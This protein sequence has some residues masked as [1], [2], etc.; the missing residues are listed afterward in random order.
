MAIGPSEIL[1][2]AFQRATQDQNHSLVEDTELRVRIEYVARNPQN[3]A[4]VRFVMACSLAKIHLPQVDIRKP[5]TE[6]GDAD[7][8]SGR[9]YDERYI[10]DFVLQHELPCNMTTA[11][12][13]PAFRNRYVTLTPDVNLV[14]RPPAIYTAALQLLEAVHN[15][16]L[17][18]E[19]L[20]AET[21]RW[22]V[23]IR[24]EKRDRMRSLLAALKTSKGETSLSAEGIVSLVEQH[25]KLRNTS[26]LPVLIVAA[27]Y[28]AAQ[29]FLGERVLPLESHNAA[30]K[31]T[32]A[33]GDLEITLIDDNQ[34]ITSYEMKA[35][36][37]T[38]DD[39]D[40][41]LDKI[42]HYGVSIHNYIFIT[43]QF[44]DR[45]VTEYAA[46]MYDKTGGIEIAILDCISFLRY[47]LHLFYRVRIE[48]L[49]AYQTLILAEPESAIS[50]PLKEA[51]L[52]MR[53]AAESNNSD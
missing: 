24:D 45:E 38:K 3:R 7:S 51:F 34:V 18:A 28:K 42:I 19:D 53:H 6:I 48:F 16:R 35:K 5:Y 27:V 2:V 37:V 40:I 41:A 39:L 36:Q 14:G 9:T 31:Q 44:I 12:L 1:H 22:L 46:S 21:L 47:F 10:L 17:S 33:L 29:N 26:R 8:Y 25:A 11:F 23:V 52:A 43:T 49:E 4:C 13:T 32:G 15:R 30:D 20:L 50:Q